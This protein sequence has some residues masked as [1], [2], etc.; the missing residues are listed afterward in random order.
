MNV[1]LVAVKTKSK[2]TGRH[3]STIGA[4]GRRDEAKEFISRYLEKFP[5]VAEFIKNTKELA[6]KNGF[7][8]TE[9]GRRRYLPEINSPNFQVAGA[10]ERMAIN[11]P[12]QGLAA[13]IVKLAMIRVTRELGANGKRIDANANGEVRPVKSGRA[14]PAEREFN[15]V[16]MILQIHDEIILEVRE[17]LAEAVSRELKR[18]MENIYK[19]KVP[20]AVD[21]K[22]GENW[23]EL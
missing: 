12:I 20:L 10:A 14:G 6:R 5:Q 15:G 4:K 23:G 22:I 1:R 11:M 19:L 8:E 21:V 18:I 3:R 2:T 13:D 9:T 7:V 17:D 16:K